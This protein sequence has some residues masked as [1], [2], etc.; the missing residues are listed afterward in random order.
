VAVQR[1]TSIQ[2][3]WGSPPS[4]FDSSKTYQQVP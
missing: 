2:I 1:S 4:G 3:R